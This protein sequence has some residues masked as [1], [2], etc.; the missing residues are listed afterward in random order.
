[1][2]IQQFAVF[3]VVALM[4]TAIVQTIHAQAAATSARPHITGISHLSVYTMDA[5]KTEYFY[6]H[7]LGGQ[8]RDDPQNPAGVRYYFSPI[9]FIEVLPMPA[10]DTSIN[11][12]DHF[13]FNTINA[14]QLRLY[15]S[16]H[17]IAVPAQIEKGSDG[18]RWFTVLDPEGNKVEFVQPPANPKPV[19]VN[20]LSVHIIHVGCIVHSPDV[21]NPFYRV[22]LGFRPYWH[23]G[24]TDTS[25]DWISQQVPDGTDW[26]EYMTVSG[27]ETK[28]IP[29]TMKQETAGVLNHFS[30]GVFNMEKTVNL[31]YAGDRLT[32]KHSPP[33]IGRD[34]KWQL[35]LYDPDGTRAELMEFQ[36][37]VKP[38][39]SE[40]TASSPVK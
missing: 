37:A 3:A 38:C 26:I 2:R 13:A 6:V 39:C 34:G 17:G 30:L 35:N 4:P 25:N 29:P 20:P 24:H 32:A 8:K 23:G 11:R 9:Q 18:S 21:E 27:P 33:Q 31:L 12:M 14:E 40:F 1:M 28:G 22:L 16:A 36:A 5:A 19:P 7:D 10:G 15:L